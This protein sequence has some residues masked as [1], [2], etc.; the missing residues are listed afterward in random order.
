MLATN[1]MVTTASTEASY[2]LAVIMEFPPDDLPATKVFFT[3][4]I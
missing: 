2:V 3:T 1:T 4:P